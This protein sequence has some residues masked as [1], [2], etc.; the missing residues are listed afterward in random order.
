MF[1]ELLKNPIFWIGIVIVVL[2]VIIVYYNTKPKLKPDVTSV[3]NSD[4]ELING[5]CTEKCPENYIRCNNGK[6][7]DPSKQ[8]CD[9]SGNICDDVLYC[10]SSN[11]CCQKNQK[12]MPDNTTCCDI[13]YIGKDNN[14]NEVCCSQKLCGQNC[15][16]SN[17]EECIDNNCVL[18]CIGNEI[19]CKNG[20]CYDPENQYCDKN[21]IICNKI[22]HCKN[23]DICCPEGQICEEST[24]TCKVCDV[25][26]NGV[27]CN[28]NQKCAV[29]NTICCDPEYIGKDMYNNEICCKEKLC[30][31]KCCLPGI[32]ECISGICT[33]KC[34]KGQ[35][36]CNNG[37][38]YDP[39]SQYCDK[40][41][42]ICNIISHCSS[43]NTCCPSGLE[44]E[45]LSNTCKVCDVR[46]NKR[47]CNK[48]EICAV[49]N[50]ICCNPKN[51]G[52][53]TKGNE[54]CCDTELC[55]GVCCDEGIGEACISGKCQIGCPNLTKLNSGLYNKCNNQD[56]IFTGNP[57]DCDY[58]TSLCLHDCTDKINPF[59]CIPK[60]STCWENTTYSPNLLL[61]NE[62][63]TYDYTLSSG[64]YKGQKTKVPVCQTAD[65][66]PNNINNLWISKGPSNLVRSVNVDPNPNNNFRNL[67]DVNTC[68]SKII[69]PT[70]GIINYDK[71]FDPD[72]KKKDIINSKI[73]DSKCNSMLSCDNSL[74]NNIEMSNLCSIFD[75][76]KITKG[77]C[78]TKTDNSGY[79]GQ[80]CP[81]N[82]ICINDK[83]VNPNT[84]Y[85]DIIKSAPMP[86]QMFNGQ[87][88][89]GDKQTYL[90]ILPGRN[91]N[92][93]GMNCGPF[94]AFPRLYNI[95]NISETDICN[96]NPVFN[97]RCDP[98]SQT[99]VNTWKQKVSSISNGYLLGGAANLN[100]SP[101]MI[102]FGVS[103][104]GCG[105]KE[106]EC[107]GSLNQC[108]QILINGNGT[109]LETDYP[110][111]TVDWVRLNQNFTA[112]FI[113]LIS[114]GYENYVSCIYIEEKII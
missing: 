81:Q 89:L 22:S 1:L 91:I 48:G 104:V 113:S 6:C 47:C 30:G 14:N 67:C 17:T 38:C 64:Q 112:S 52:K 87:P 103:T 99:F 108:Y 40:N 42:V 114:T 73:I 110:A 51:I 107:Q 50:T 18:K 85:T 39:S 101:T 31:E 28:N 37:D 27:C 84:Y 63:V 21:G 32:E 80:I 68:I 20:V 11:T 78:C 19:R 105:G 71:T 45:E 109:S 97:N 13:D 10:K 75:T 70:S 7:Y 44:C 57:V 41:G 26:C 16:D 5:I 111:M 15:C 76:D 65:I 54:T 33:E 92:I 56:I 29:Y 4:Q 69:E 88:I 83:C 53:D 8:Y 102:S 25:D 94:L 46:C 66:D 77:R 93:Y 34:Q 90:Y 96:S 72:S 106:I 59:K 98:Q 58:D 35:T 60:T 3:C 2:T 12:C 61:Y 43:S 79:T 23:S 49:N 62:D 24:N 9:K 82:Y 74:L 55:N 95:I 36:R 86:Y 100:K